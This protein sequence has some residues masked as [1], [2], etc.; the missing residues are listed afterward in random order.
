MSPSDVTRWTPVVL[1]FN[2]CPLR[3]LYRIERTEAINCLGVKFWEAMVAAM[4]DYSDATTY[5]EGTTYEIGEVVL[6]S[7]ARYRIATKQTTFNPD[8]AADWNDAPKFAKSGSCAADY[9]D[10]FCTFLGPWLAFVVLSE[11]LPYIVTPVT[12]Q[13]IEYG[14]RKINAQDADRYQTLERAI[15]RDREKSYLLLEEFLSQPTNREKTCFQ[16]WK[17][18]EETEQPTCG[19]NKATCDE[20]KKRRPRHVGRYRWG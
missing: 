8:Y 20:C 19:C 11:R 3:E 10:L 2:P 12:D 14:G 4:A 13:G 9:E 1:D 16:L 5:T 17:G 18:N 7:N 6:W 15:F